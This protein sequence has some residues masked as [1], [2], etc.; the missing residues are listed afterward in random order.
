MRD[1]TSDWEGENPVMTTPRY[2]VVTGE[3]S[4]QRPAVPS[5]GSNIAPQPS[6]SAAWPRFATGVVAVWLFISAFA[7]P[8]NYGLRD[9]TWVVAV[10]MFGV[11]SWAVREP[12]VRVINT[13]LSIWLF[14]ST[15]FMGG[16][17][18]ATLW[19]NIIV[20][21]VVFVLSLTPTMGAGA[22][23]RL[24]GHPGR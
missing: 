19:N 1:A 10:L 23:S 11:S 9:N 2:P 20:A 14:V 7:W 3:P 18:P 21:F 22:G 24:H 5:G 15:I 12:S 4:E 13:A 16:H 17:N 6:E 8:H